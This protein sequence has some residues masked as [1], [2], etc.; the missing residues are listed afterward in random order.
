LLA[1]QAYLF[2]RENG[3]SENNPDIYAALSTIVNDQVI[4]RGHDDAV[5]GVALSGD[6]KFLVSCGDDGNIFRWNPADPSAAPVAYKLPKGVKEK[7]RSVLITRDG[8]F[9]IAGSFSGKIYIL[10][11][12]PSASY[13]KVL[14]GHTSIVNVLSLHPALNQFASAGSDGRVILWTFNADKFSSSLIDSSS[15][16]IHALTFARG[17]K[18]IA[19]GGSDGKLVTLD[20]EQGR[21]S[22]STL[23]T[24][25]D[26]VLSLASSN[27]GKTL[28]AGFTNGSIRLWDMASPG[29]EPL[30]LLGRH[31]SGV[32]SL[33][34]SP[35]GDE[36]ASSSYDRTIRI[37][38]RKSSEGKPI[39]IEKY[40]LWVYGVFFTADGSRLISCGADK[41][42]RIFSTGCRILNDRL[43]RQL[44]R[45][46]T[47]E[48]WGKYVGADIPYQKTRTELP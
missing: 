34:F 38:T 37:G 28:A 42:I 4:L 14:T 40:D 31:V 26:P 23:F 43:S 24:S 9:V 17:G 33:A 3:G 1:V 19:W 18:L 36:L 2:N 7:F 35:G 12:D 6:G 16:R 29:N 30:E 45:N 8:G 10:K 27:D 46:L 13:V 41:S 47:Q 44:K 11:S 25:G 5:R 21:S 20:P 32:T 48:E 15:A 22:R 39:S